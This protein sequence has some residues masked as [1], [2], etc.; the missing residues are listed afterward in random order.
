MRIRSFVGFLLTINILIADEQFVVT[1]K[2]VIGEIATVQSFVGT[3][4]YNTISKLASQSAAVV[5]K[6]F[7]DIGDEIQA[8]DTIAKQD[9]AMLDAEVES[10]KAELARA[11]EDLD[12]AAKD[13]SRYEILHS[14][15]S[16]SNQ[17]FEQ[18][19]LKHTYAK[20]TYEKAL[21]DLTQLQIERNNRVIKAPFTGAITERFVSVGEWATVGAP[22]ATLAKLDSVEV[23]LFLPINRLHLATIKKDVRVEILGKNYTGT[24]VGVSKQGDKVTRSA[25]VRIAIKNPSDLIEGMEARVFLSSELEKKALLVDRDA[26]INRFGKDVVFYVENGVAKMASVEIISFSDTLVAIRSNAIKSGSDVVTKGNERIF[27][28]DKVTVIAQ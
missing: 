28:D 21:S 23:A 13:L 11:K 7:V 10:K 19:K 18:F 2:A 8:G 3:V 9:S 6:I 22:I 17:Q 1:Q 5:E 20:A 12:L 25:L 27:P 14:E 15:N 26:V 16:I 4:K 24:I